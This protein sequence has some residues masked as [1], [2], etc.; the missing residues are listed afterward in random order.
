MRKVTDEL[1]TQKR[2]LSIKPCPFCGGPGEMDGYYDSRRNGFVVKCVHDYAMD[3]ELCAVAPR[4]MPRKTR[5]LAIKAWNHRGPLEPARRPKM[6]LAIRESKIIT[7]GKPGW[8]D[9]SKPSPIK[10]GYYFDEERQRVCKPNLFYGERN[11]L[12]FGLNGAGKS[13]RFLVEALVTLKNRSIFVFD[14]K[15][16]LAAMTARTRRKF[17]KVYIINPYGE[18]GLPSD[19]IN[20]LASIDVDDEN[21]FFRRCVRVAS[22]IIELPAKGEPHWSESAEGFFQ[23]GIM[24]ECLEAK[25]Q[26][27]APSLWRVRLLL[28]EADEFKGVGEKRVQTKGLL[29]N[30]ARMVTHGGPIIASLVGRF[31]REHGQNELSGIQSTFDTQTRFLLDPPLARDLE[32]DGVDFRKMRDECITVYCIVPAGM[33]SQLRRFTRLVVSTALSDQLRPGRV[34]SLFVL[35]EFRAAVGNL[36][37]VRE[38]WALVRGYGIQLMPFCQSATQLEALMDKE[39]E[40]FTAQAGAVVTIGPPNDD[41]SAEWMSKRSGTTTMWQ[42]GMNSGDSMGM[43]GRT[44]M[45]DGDNYSQGERRFLLP[46]ELRSMKKGFGR[47]WTPGMGDRSIPFFAPNHWHV[48]ALKGLVDPNPYRTA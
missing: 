33:I 27:R 9:P 25:R 14:I 47:I 11:L 34:K 37:I 30:A 23:A 38:L 10:I 19:G 16:E 22:A 28:T 48:S 26:G 4:T 20:P 44:N 36:D 24:W 12:I 42:H 1:A 21:Q 46:Q 29:V 13:T 15:A 45:N 40:N 8:F 5:A 41:L 31:L 6:A 32:K 35:D 39:W 7:R 17:S 2:Q 3:P 43:D 18:L